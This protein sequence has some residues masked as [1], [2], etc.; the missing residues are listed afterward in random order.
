MTDWLKLVPEQLR[1]SLSKADEAQLRR[2]AVS[3]SRRVVDVVGLDDPRVRRILER[4]R[5]RFG[6]T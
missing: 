1:D 6:G 2:V 5:S 3:L 4:A